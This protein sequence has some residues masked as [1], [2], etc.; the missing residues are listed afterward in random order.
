M[1]DLRKYAKQ[2]NIRLFIGFFII[3]FLI[4]D[5]LI[6]LIYSKEAAIMGLLCLIVGLIPL[7]VIFAFFL[8]LDWIVARA[9]EY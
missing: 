2:T 9:K 1:R 5:G 8:L 3:L 4:G 7:I 6:A